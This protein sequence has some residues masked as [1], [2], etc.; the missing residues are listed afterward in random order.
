M[1]SEQRALD[2]RNGKIRQVSFRPFRCESLQAAWDLS[3]AERV[4]L[5]EV[6]PIDGLVGA[7][8]GE[9][10]ADIDEVVYER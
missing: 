2:V 3:R 6:E 5:G 7:F 10:E 9:P 4:D 8:E 1:A